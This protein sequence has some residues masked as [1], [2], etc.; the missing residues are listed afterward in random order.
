MT[1]HKNHLQLLLS[2]FLCFSALLL[3]SCSN[4]S[5]STSKTAVQQASSDKQIFISPIEGQADIKTFDPALATDVASV[6]I[7]NMI[8]TGL[9]Q[10]DDKLQVRDQLAASHTLAADGTTWTFKLKDNLRFSDGTPLTSMDVAYSIDRALQPATKSGIAPVYLGLIKDSDKLNSGALKTIINDSLLTPDRQTIIIKTSKKSVYFL[11]ALTY[12]SSYI[13]EKSMIDKYG[14]DF[15][16]HLNEGIGGAGPWKVSRYQPGVD[17]R[18]VPNEHY[19]GK[20]PQLRKIVMPFYKEEDTTYKAYQANQVDVSTVPSTIVKMAQKLPDHQYHQVPQ[21][22][23][24]F[25]IMNYLIKPFDNIKIRQAFALAID[26]DSIS[27]NIYKDT[28]IAT[29]HIVPQGMSG[30]NPELVGPGNEKETKGNIQ[31]AQQLFEQGMKE[32]GYTRATFPGITLSVATKGDSTA[33][34]EFAAVQQMWQKALGITV[35]VRDEEVNKLNDDAVATVNNPKG[36]Q[37]WSNDWIG[38]YPDPQDWLTGLFGK[39][40]SNNWGNYGQ[41]Y[42]SAATEQ[43]RMQQLMEQADEN[44]DAGARTKQYN[45]AEQSM[46]N[47]VAWIPRYQS[48]YTYLQKSCVVGVVDNAQQLVPPDDWGAIYKSTSS[49]CAN[50]GS[51]N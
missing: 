3:M 17:I 19:Y 25:Y 30:Y 41:N 45:T 1:L 8:F 47:D 42:T 46:V 24:H 18:F 37:L 44:Q 2:T 43:Q 35:K 48:A 7:I 31:K 36:L 34:S 33:R 12:P 9:V 21:L 11:Q 14:T 49:T 39:G 40:S 6:Q 15:S 10:L 26:K 28:A 13:V 50:T 5:L 27:H 20:K 32:A 51:Y 29:N 4:G 16:R 22:W 23:E 38:D